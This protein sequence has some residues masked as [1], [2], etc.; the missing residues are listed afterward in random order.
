MPSEQLYKIVRFYH[1]SQNRE[2]EVIETDLTLAEARAHCNDPS[3]HEEGVFFDGYQPQ[4][5]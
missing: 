1:P 5:D 2:K 3:T 4:D